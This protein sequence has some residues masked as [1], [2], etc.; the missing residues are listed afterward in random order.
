MPAN[1]FNFHKSNKI[2]IINIGTYIASGIKQKMVKMLTAA[3]SIP[4]KLEEL[5]MG[6]RKD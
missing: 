5:I 3:E 6:L 1:R 4:G 2:N